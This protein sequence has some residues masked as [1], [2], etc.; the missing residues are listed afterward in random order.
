MG[1]VG[2]LRCQAKLGVRGNLDVAGAASEVGDGNAP[3]LCIV[4]GR[5]DHLK[6]GAQR[7]VA[8]DEFSAVFVERNLVSVRF[9][10]AWLVAC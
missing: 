1:H 3:N 6:R 9:N 7:V 5:H 2:R 10:A 4:L 8:P